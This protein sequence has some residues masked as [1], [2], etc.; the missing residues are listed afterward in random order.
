MALEAW[1]FVAHFFLM[2]FAAIGHFH[3][4]PGVFTDSG[5]VLSPDILAVTG[6]AIFLVRLEAFRFTDIPM[7][8]LAFHLSHLHV[9]SMGEEHAIG[10]S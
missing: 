6:Y 2:A 7:A 4:V 1:A 9:G 10:L 8:F 3:T 5:D